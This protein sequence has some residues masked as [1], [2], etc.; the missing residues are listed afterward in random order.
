M[1]GIAGIVRSDSAQIDRELLTRMND[2]IRHRGPDDDGFYF[3]D[4]VGLAMRRLSIIDLKG[5]HQPIHNSDRTA[6][7]VFNGEIYN[8][9]E[10]RKQLEARG[11]RFYTDSDTE[12]IVHAYDEY[13][14]D[15]P[16]YLRGMFAFAIWDER[17]KSLFL[18][19]DRVGKKPLLYAQ[20]NGQLIFGSEF[21]ALLQHPDVSRDVNYEAIHHYLSFICVPAPLTAYQAI[22]K[23]QPGHSLLWKNGEIKLERYW[24]LDF[25][26]KISISEEEAGERVVDLLRDA[27]RVRL[28]SE[29]PLGAF[30]SGDWF[31]RTGFQ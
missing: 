17:A 4:G 27:V 25:S 22:R 14:T 31:R 24:R 29:V 16:K 23:L 9:R 15:C 10:L 7:I 13:G 1:C 12:A 20:L 11:H 21:M 19:R 5:G 26:R 3:S 6:W 30:L 18:A 8:Y 28:M 2:A